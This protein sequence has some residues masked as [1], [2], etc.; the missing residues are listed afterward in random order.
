MPVEGLQA[1]NISSKVVELTWDPPT[2]SNGPITNYFLYWSSD[3]V[4]P[5]SHMTI[6]PDVH[7][8]VLRSLVP[9][10]EYNI[11]VCA[12]NIAGRSENRSLTVLTAQAGTYVC[13]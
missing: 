1:N 12:A 3:G 7:Q 11:T 2:H 13:T 5:D 9:H 4:S 6:P 8:F 10:T